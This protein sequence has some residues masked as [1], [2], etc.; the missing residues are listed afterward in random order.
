MGTKL[1][2][3][4]RRREDLTAV[5][6][7]DY[8]ENVHVPLITRLLPFWAD[9]R[10]NYLDDTAQQVGHHAAR[11][12]SHRPFDVITE[13]TYADDDM[14]RRVTDALRDPRIGALIAADEANFMD[15]ESMQTFLVDEHVSPA[16]ESEE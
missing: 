2:T 4:I 6:F 9:Y 3:L 8:Y 15:R 16:R 13:L 7:R 1:V 12:A 5:E 14:R 11:R 10:R